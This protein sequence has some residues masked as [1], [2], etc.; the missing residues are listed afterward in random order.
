MR[1]IMALSSLLPNLNR[2]L[3]GI[4]QQVV[5]AVDPLEDFRRTPY[6]ASLVLGMCLKSRSSQAKPPKSMA[7]SLNLAEM[8][9]RWGW[10]ES[11]TGAL[12][13]LTAL[14]CVAVGA[15]YLAS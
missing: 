6:N 4:V 7:P 5:S 10:S 14:R 9:Q 13:S 15:R 8:C 11:V 2:M 1:D 12:A 3:D